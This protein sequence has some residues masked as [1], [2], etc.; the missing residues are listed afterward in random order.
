MNTLAIAVAAL[1]AG[2]PDAAV[3]GT[4][5]VAPSP[6]EVVAGLGALVV[7]VVGVLVVRHLQAPGDGP[8]NPVVSPD[9]ANDHL[10]KAA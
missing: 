9:P 8:R 5:G 7:A 6:I 2:L 10:R 3:S 1:P 4:L